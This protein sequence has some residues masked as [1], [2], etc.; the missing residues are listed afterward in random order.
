METTFIEP[1]LT[2]VRYSLYGLSMALISKM[3]SS[4]YHFHNLLQG[5]AG[6]IGLVPGGKNGKVTSSH[7]TSLELKRYTTQ[8]CTPNDEIII[9]AYKYNVL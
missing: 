7:I 4:Y 9:K 3:T 8:A 2:F 6:I 1:T 5:L